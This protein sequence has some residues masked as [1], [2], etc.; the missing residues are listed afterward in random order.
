MTLNERDLRNAMSLVAVGREDGGGLGL[1]TSLLAGLTTLVSCDWVTVLEHDVRRQQGLYGATYPDLTDSPEPDEAGFWSHFWDSPCSY[2]E[3]TGDI[4]HAITL[5]DASPGRR[6]EDSGLYADYLRHLDV[7]AYVCVWLSVSGDRSVK[8][9][10]SRTLDINFTE[11]DRLLLEVLRPHLA[12]LYRQQTPR[13]RLTRR[14]RQLLDLVAAGLTNDQAARRLGIAEGTVRKHMERI[15]EQL[16][17]ASRA[18][19]VAQ[20]GPRADT[21]HFA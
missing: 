1:P 11:R 9:F 6:F 10:F 19:A 7:H 16:G 13:D 5:A 8:L 14:Q 3:R 15:L 20:A 18:A 2:G 12:E 17:V 4:Y 21:R